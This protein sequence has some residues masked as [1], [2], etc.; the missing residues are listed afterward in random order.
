MIAAMAGETCYHCGHALVGEQ[1]GPWRTCPYCERFVHVPSQRALS[2]LDRLRRQI[3]SEL[4]VGEAQRRELWELLTRQRSQALAAV[5]A[6]RGPELPPPLPQEPPAVAASAAVD[7]SPAVAS[8]PAPPPLPSSGPPLVEPS[9]DEPGVWSRLGPLFAENLLFALAGFLLVAGAVYFTTTAWTTMSGAMQKLVVAGG[10]LLFAGLLHGAA[11]VL[12][13]DA[14]LRVAARA[15]SLVAVALAPSASVAAS[16][17]HAE[18]VTLA[19]V[20][21]AAAAGAQV[22]FLRALVRRENQTLPAAVAAASALLVFGG[23]FAVAW[24]PFRVF[25]SCA[26]AA[27]APSLSWWSRRRFVPQSPSAD[28]CALAG[29]GFAALALAIGMALAAGTTPGAAAAP[30]GV[31]VAALSLAGMLIAGR[32]AA[33]SPVALTVAYAAGISAVLLAA[34]DVRC[35]MVAAWAAAATGLLASLRLERARLLAPALVLSAV[36]YLFLPAPVRE[37][38]ARLREQAAGQLGYAGQQLPLSFYGITF[39]P[40]LAGLALLT[41]W[42]RRTGRNAHRQVTS[43]FAVATALGL[44]AM[45]LLLGR[46]LRAP[47]AVLP[48]D[49]LLLVLLGRLAHS[50][51]AASIGWLGVLGGVVCGLV[52]CEVQNGVATAVLAAVI[53]ALLAGTRVAETNLGPVAASRRAVGAAAAAALAVWPLVCV[54]PLERQGAWNLLHATALLPV[55][56]AWYGLARAPGA[57]SWQRWAGAWLVAPPS[58]A[59]A[60]GVAALLAEVGFARAWPAMP[61]ALAVVTAPLLAAVPRLRSLPDGESAARHLALGLFA[62]HALLVPSLCAAYAVDA[63]AWGTIAG[64]AALAVV[65]AWLAAAARFDALLAVAVVEAAWPLHLL[66]IVVFGDA[67]GPPGL[68]GPSVLL[69]AVAWFGASRQALCVTAAAGAVLFLLLLAAWRLA[70]FPTQPPVRDAAVALGIGLAFAG[71]SAWQLARRP[72]GFEQAAWRAAGVLS[73][74]VCPVTLLDLYV[75]GTAGYAWG[76]LVLGALIC[77]AATRVPRQTLPLSVYGLLH[78]CASVTLWFCWQPDAQP[79]VEPTAE[80][81]HVQRLCGFV[82]VG[83]AAALCRPRE[84]RTP[85]TLVALAAG[86]GAGVLQPVALQWLPSEWAAVPAFGGCALALAA[87]ALPPLRARGFAVRLV[88]WPAVVVATSLLAAAAIMAVTGRQPRAPGGLA[89][90]DANAA[91]LGLAALGLAVQVEER[92]R[93]WLRWSV[94]TVVLAATA[95]VNGLLH[96]SRVVA[97]SPDVEIALLA[98]ALAALAQK[99]ATAAAF[100][101]AALL[102]TGFDLAD[103]STPFAVTLVAGVPLALLLRRLPGP[104]VLAHGALLLLATWSWIAY[105]LAG[106]DAAR[107]GPWLGLSAAV[108]GAAAGPW[109]RFCARD[110]AGRAELAALQAACWL[111][112]LGALHAAC[113]GDAPMP[114]LALA[115]SLVA[116]ALVA[117]GSA[118]GA[119]TA[120]HEVLVH[121]ALVALVT[122]YRVLATG[123]ELLHPLLGLHHHGLTVLGATLFVVAGSRASAMCGQLRA[124]A[125]VAPLLAIALAVPFGGQTFALLAGAAVMA[126]GAAVAR[127][128]LLAAGAL[129]LANCGLFRLWLREGVLDPSFYGVPAGLSLVLGAELARGPLGAAR[130]LA[131][132]VAGLA[133]AYGSVLVQIARV[134][135]PAHAVAL[136]V[137]AMLAV[138]WGVRRQQAAIL[139]TGVVAVVLDVVVYLAQRGFQQDFVG[140]M[141]LVGA[142]GSVFVVAARAARARARVAERPPV[143]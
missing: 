67:A 75:T 69:V 54:W 19:L 41:A 83:V 107:L 129:L 76:T 1:L 136:F 53:M 26:A 143:R 117:M 24:A 30:V 17:L 125:V 95:P 33:P 108:L 45:S 61:A 79:D 97:P 2:A 112:A 133:V 27:V 103:V 123:S 100:G 36:G 110:S 115:A 42:F 130:V 89:L 93:A 131:L 38:A 102:L 73:A 3:E 51:R 80:I 90:L 124:A 127:V 15:L 34:G 11:A 135:V 8:P 122:G 58:W 29:A 56:I 49:G 44:A 18:N 28:L 105:A 116:S 128:R 141:L 109:L 78:L 114:A 47:M 40:Y 96:G 111:A 50:A 77:A 113:S 126:L 13:R 9:R 52:W 12:G 87:T 142:G 81:G 59:T 62:L 92:L 7:P 6:M 14:A 22:V 20:V 98:L 32:A 121:L 82:A 48:A 86:F 43:V 23:V 91:V 88:A 65:A 74:V 4:D 66:A 99:P 118:R 21:G 119:R 37:L 137:L 10:L 57:Q 60:T 139:V 39:L 64:T 85:S 5:I 31:V 46:D 70:A 55:A 104:F 120:G 25:T 101:A 63:V 138:A 132:R 35:V 134:S 84:L 16:L 68:L 106:R 140:S 72:G 71:L 94:A